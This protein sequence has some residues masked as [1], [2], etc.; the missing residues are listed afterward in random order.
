M[1]LHSFT[2]ARIWNCSFESRMLPVKLRES[3]SWLTRRPSRLNTPENAEGLS[4][5]CFL[6]LPASAEGAQQ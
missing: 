2:L 4:V 5:A 6:P 1:A 3:L